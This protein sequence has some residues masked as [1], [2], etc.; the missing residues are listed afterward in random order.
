[1]PSLV[2]T[3][4]YSL[5]VV[6]C[7]SMAFPLVYTVSIDQTDRKIVSIGVQICFN[8]TVERLFKLTNCLCVYF[9]F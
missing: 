2:F 8:S 1:M 3:C 5:T 6:L 4:L 9:V 7:F